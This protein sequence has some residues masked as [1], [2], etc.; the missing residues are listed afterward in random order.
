[1]IR[2]WPTCFG[3]L[4]VTNPMRSR[5]D[6]FLAAA[7]AAAVC[8]ALWV[9]SA[10]EPAV[11]PAAAT[12]HEASPAAEPSAPSAPAATEVAGRRVAT[13]Q[14]APRPLDE[15][16]SPAAGASGE[17]AAAAPLGPRKP[18]R[19]LRIEV[20]GPDTYDAARARVHHRVQR[21]N[22]TTVWTGKV[23]TPRREGR[24]LVVDL[25][26]NELPASAF[27]LRVE[28]E[29][30]AYSSGWVT[31]DRLG[32]PRDVLVVP[33]LP[34]TTVEVKVHVAHGHPVEGCSVQIELA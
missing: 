11:E 5:A 33:V 14:E 7:A 25:E 9:A 12:P 2:A 10:V 13:P 27:D 26:A 17:P 32:P 15:A 23:W 31:L 8:V 28:L 1:M 34:V 24:Q 4:P 16:T 6:S 20:A 3:V 30:G 19:V 21:R 18:T 29:G 22:G